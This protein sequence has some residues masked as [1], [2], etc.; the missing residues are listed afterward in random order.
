MLNYLVLLEIRKLLRIVRSFMH[1][2]SEVVK[3]WYVN[4]T[5]VSHHRVFA[6]LLNFC[7]INPAV[8]VFCVNRVTIA[9]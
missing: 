7:Q 8:S 1:E 4:S 9:S 5:E 3:M 6:R 2:W